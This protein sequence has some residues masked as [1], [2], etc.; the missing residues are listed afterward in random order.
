MFAFLDLLK[1][2][3]LSFQSVVSIVSLAQSGVLSRTGNLPLFSCFY[4]Y[5]RVAY[6]KL[7]QKKEEKSKSIYFP[8]TKYK[9]KL[10]PCI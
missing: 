3:A 7:K 10:A 1:E 8:S 9:K 4:A 6:E 5:F 2:L